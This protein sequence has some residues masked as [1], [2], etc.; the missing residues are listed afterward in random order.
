[1]RS[2]TVKKRLS[3]VLPLI[4]LLIG[5]MACGSSGG[6][7]A[8]NGQDSGSKTSSESGLVKPTNTPT[9]EELEEPTKPAPGM[10][11]GFQELELETFTHP[12]V[13]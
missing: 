2:Y 12:S 3:L 11:Q 7:D 1:M 8:S 10:E 13:F 5:A 4:V 9:G 6:D